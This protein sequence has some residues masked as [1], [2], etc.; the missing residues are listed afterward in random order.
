MKRH[1]LL[2]EEFLRL[3]ELSGKRWGLTLYPKAR[4]S[5][6]Y[7]MLYQYYRAGRI[8]DQLATSALLEAVEKAAIAQAKAKVKAEVRASFRLGSTRD[9]DDRELRRSVHAAMRQRAT[10][11]N[12]YMR[13][14]VHGSEGAAR[15]TGE[16]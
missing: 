4:F 3:A 15:Q 12:A 1:P 13:E 11:T 16:V 2:W 14:G 9:L 6:L 10:A 8:F 5:Y 7:L